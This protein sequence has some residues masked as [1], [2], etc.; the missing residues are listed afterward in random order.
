MLE[1]FLACIGTAG[2]LYGIFAAADDAI[3]VQTKKEISQYLSKVKEVSLPKGWTKS[4]A[5][6]FDAIYTPKHFS[7]RCFFRSCISSLIAIAIIYAIYVSIN[8]GTDFYSAF[9]FSNARAIDYLILILAPI[10]L[11]FIP[12]YVSLLET[13]FVLKKLSSGGSTLFYVFLDIL[14]TW[15]IATSAYF[16]GS[17][18]LFAV[19]SGFK[20]I[21]YEL[22]I[23]AYFRDVIWLQTYLV[24]FPFGV[25]FYS[26]FIT[27]IWLWLFIL[28][29]YIVRK[30][31]AALKHASKYI[32]YLNIEEYPLKSIGFVSMILTILIYIFGY[33][34]IL[35]TRQ[36]VI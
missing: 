28:G 17:F 11:N 33:V 1:Y 16:I 20:D 21:E 8:R 14:L 5:A 3:A 29:V 4:F 24:P 34:L 32:R 6:V 27:S 22:A 9:N 23:A 30:L 26:T 12:D 2:A 19:D 7:F 15:L 13:R 10:L 25:L 36:Q 31:Y 35:L 18:V